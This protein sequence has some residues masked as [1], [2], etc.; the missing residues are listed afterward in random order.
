MD[1]SRRA[2][3]LRGQG[4]WCLKTMFFPKL[5]PSP[6]E[7]GADRRVVALLVQ[8]LE[9]LEPQTLG[10]HGRRLGRYFSTPMC[11]ACHPMTVADRGRHVVSRNVDGPAVRVGARR[12]VVGA[13]PHSIGLAAACPRDGLVVE[14]RA[15]PVFY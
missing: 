12:R 4:T 13:P 6:L 1:N 7:R 10:E 11:G 2:A 15:L 3:A 9:R 5:V 8:C 14:R